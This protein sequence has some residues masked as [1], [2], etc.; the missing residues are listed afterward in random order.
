MCL[1]ERTEE[2][3]VTRAVRLGWLPVLAAALAVA[4]DERR[5]ARYASYRDAVVQGAVHRGWIPAYVPQSA[6]EIAEVHNLDTNAQLLRFQ[7]PPEALTAM[8]ARLTPMPSRKAPPPPRYLA[9]PGGD[10]WRRDLGSGTVPEGMAV[11]RAHLDPGG[12][13]CVVV[14]ARGLTAYAWT[15]SDAGRMALPRSRPDHTGP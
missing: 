2:A 11:Y 8:T 12:V 1:V 3:K 7:A 10:L 5:E 13:H 4:C 14:D 9:P 6:T 15:C